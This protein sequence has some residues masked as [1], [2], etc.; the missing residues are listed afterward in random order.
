M[1]VLCDYQ[2]YGFLEIELLAL[3][4]KN[5]I[6][7]ELVIRLQFAVIDFLGIGRFQKTMRF[8]LSYSFIAEAK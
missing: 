8:T 3:D 7:E 5:F 2:R 6:Q 4:A 1:I